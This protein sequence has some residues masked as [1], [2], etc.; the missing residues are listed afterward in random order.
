MTADQNNNTITISKDA[1]SSGQVE[2]KLWLCRQIEKLICDQEAQT[3]W[4]LG[5]W[6]GLLSFLL[7]SRER[8]K[9]KSIRSFDSNPICKKQAYIINNNWSWK[10]WKF[11]AKTIDCNELN[12]ANKP[13]TDQS[14]DKAKK[15]DSEDIDSY[16]SFYDSD[17]PS[18]IINTSIEHFKSNKWYLN[19]PNG[20]ILALQSCDMKHED[21]I[22]LVYSEDEFKDQFQFT[23]LHYSGTL[24]F[25]YKTHSFSRYMLIFEK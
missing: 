23:K 15:T 3:I 1:Y 20:T 11:K 10:D 5:G 22:S 8:L 19:I 12:Y 17:K 25:D 16:R 7:L 14:G 18:L 9:I 21:H 13:L 2:S 24:T 6:V 4:I